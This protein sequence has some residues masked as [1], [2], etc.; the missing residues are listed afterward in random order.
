MDSAHQAL[1]CVQGKD[2]LAQL[3]TLLAKVLLQRTKSIIF[4]KLPKKINCV[5][6]VELSG[7]QR[8][9]YEVR[10]DLFLL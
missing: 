9:C 2:R 8:R 4:D 1:L 3:H 10:P 6:F 5:V 7:L